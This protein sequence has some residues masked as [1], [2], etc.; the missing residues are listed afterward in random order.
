MAKTAVVIG[1]TG[2]VG[3]ELVKQL[4]LSDAFER[5][6]TMT[7]RAL[8]LESDKHQNHLIDFEKLD[9]YSGLFK[10]DALFSCLGTTRKQAGSVAEQ[11][12]IDYD[13]QLQ[14]AKIAARNDIPHY[15]LISSSGAN[16]KSSAAYM[17]M[18]GELE[19]DVKE[20]PF[21][22]ISIFQPSLL[23]GSRDKP[24]LGE[25]IA[26]YIMPV[27]CRMPFLRKY[28]PITGQ[29]VARRMLEVS[30]SE[31]NSKEYFILEDVFPKTG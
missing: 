1:A 30:L 3:K 28:R 15:L 9:R 24:R 13:Y 17:K 21:K 10:G 7:R 25:G 22:R 31:G 23:L 11:R 29:Q 14:V 6:V 27:L 20:L 19:D 4:I 2:L 8:E 26:A 5:V 16:A 18:K 12:R